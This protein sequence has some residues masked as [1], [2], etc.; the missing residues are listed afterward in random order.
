MDKNCVTYQLEHKK[1]SSFNKMNMNNN[2]LKIGE[3]NFDKL[4]KFK[5][6]VISCDIKG[7]NNCD[8]EIKIVSDLKNNLI[9]IKFDSPTINKYEKYILL[10]NKK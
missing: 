4:R 2:K 3:I 5:L 9:I 7:T 8:E 1:Y 6:I 10:E